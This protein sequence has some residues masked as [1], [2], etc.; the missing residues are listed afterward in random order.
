MSNVIVVVL[1]QFVL[2]LRKRGAVSQKQF[3]ILMDRLE[4]RESLINTCRHLKGLG[5]A[6]PPSR[7]E[8]LKRLARMAHMDL[9]EQILAILRGLT[10]P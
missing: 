2:S 10:K 6:A 1:L 9:L 5:A 4:I 8:R 7:L 3:E